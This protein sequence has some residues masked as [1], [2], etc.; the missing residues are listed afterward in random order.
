MYFVYTQRAGRLGEN[1]VLQASEISLVGWKEFGQTD[2]WGEEGS[3]FIPLAL[4][5][6]PL[7]FPFNT[8][9]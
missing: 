5:R 3:K 6:T 4:E 8:N 1:N 9:L 7:F 2:T